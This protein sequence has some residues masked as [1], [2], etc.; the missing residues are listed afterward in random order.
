MKKEIILKSWYEKNPLKLRIKKYTLGT[1]NEWNCFSDE[2]LTLNISYEN[3]ISW[4][5]Q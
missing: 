5:I 2:K 4:K 3:K 1:I